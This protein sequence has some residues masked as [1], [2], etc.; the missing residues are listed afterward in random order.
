[1]TTG[2]A[3]LQAAAAEQEAKKAA[4][5]DNAGPYA[6]F[7][8]FN[9]GETYI[10]RFLEQGDDVQWCWVHDLPKEPGK[11]FSGV[12]PCLNQDGRGNSCPGCEMNVK[13]KI[14]GWINVIVRNAPKFERDQ[15]GKLV[16][17]PMTQ[18]PNIVG[19]EDA[20]M[21]WNSG[22]RLFITLGNKDRSFKGLM[23]RD[24]EV[25]R[26]GEGL[27]T[28]YAIEPADADAGPQPMSANDKKL[29]A[30]KYDTRLFT[31]PED[32]DV[33]KQLLMG[34]PR[35]VLREAQ[36]VPDNATTNIFTQK[37]A[38]LG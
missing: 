22:S 34:V 25:L 15:D 17:N 29:A 2:L 14:T 18:R 38:E 32:Y 9:P 37:L 4:F 12:T 36:T 3:G 10:V 1:M 11:N 26:T 19:T 28:Q 27:A 13:R 23:S 6:R 8:K 30:E 16:K 24:F 31:Q 7:A 21:V 5:K 33:A 20:V 35:S